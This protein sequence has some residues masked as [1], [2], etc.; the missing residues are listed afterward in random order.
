MT[1]I[2]ALGG[3]LGHYTRARALINTLDIRGPVTLAVTQP[4][5]GSLAGFGPE[6]QV[7]SPPE[8]MSQNPT[9][10]RQWLTQSLEQQVY[11][12]IVV[13]A[14][15]AG[16][17]GELCDFPF[18]EGIRLLHVA[19]LLRWSQ[20]QKVFQGKLPAY[21]VTYVV[22]A[23][24]AVHHQA[25]AERSENMLELTLQDPLPGP[26]MTPDR[27]DNTETPLW[28]IVHS[29]PEDEIKALLAL[30][31]SMA[32]EEGLQPKQLLLSPVRPSQLPVDIDHIHAW[33][34]HPWFE[35]ADRIFT[36]CGFNSMRQ[37]LPYRHKHV[38]MP[39]ERRFDDQFL[40]A[41]RARQGSS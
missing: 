24:T 12:Q 1:F 33:P 27:R 41:A 37:L 8:T 5:S 35:L 28:L 3:G 6:L 34:A 40:R 36:A 26:T 20:Y 13:D 16:L 30:A 25:L 23:L 39:M 21:H 18:P 17:F 10:L 31:G 9:L 22:E 15:P 4:T 38:F 7:L 2:Y 32:E 29:G 14:F 11:R 19:R